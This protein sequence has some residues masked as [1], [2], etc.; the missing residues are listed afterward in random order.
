MVIKGVAL[1]KETLSS[2]DTEDLPT[3]IFTP[4]MGQVLGS[5]ALIVVGIGIT[6]GV[7]LLGRSKP[8]KAV[9]NS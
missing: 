3:E 1:T 4:E 5:L 8:Q 9:P 2:V 6:Y 7:S